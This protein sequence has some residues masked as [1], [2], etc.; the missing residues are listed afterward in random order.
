ME[1]NIKVIKWALDKYNIY[2]FISNSI[3]DFKINQYQQFQL[4]TPIDIINTL[5]QYRLTFQSV[6]FTI[7]IAQHFKIILRDNFLSI[8]PVVRYFVNRSSKSV[9]YATVLCNTLKNRKS[10]FHISSKALENH[11]IANILN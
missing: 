5:C 2:L 7:T 3:E 10:K 6:I 1:G 11:E 9:P 4:R 8:L